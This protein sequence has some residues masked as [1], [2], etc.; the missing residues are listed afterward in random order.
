MGVVRSTGARG[1]GDMR[2]CLLS[3]VGENY[4]HQVLPGFHTSAPLETKQ[5]VHSPLPPNPEMHITSVLVRVSIT[6]KR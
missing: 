3:H 2:E 4:N 5:F 6:V 1:P